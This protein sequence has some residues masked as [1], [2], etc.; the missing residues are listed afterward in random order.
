VAGGTVTSSGLTVGDGANA[1]SLTLSSSEAS[2]QTSDATVRS[3]SG[4]VLQNGAAAV[5]TSS[6]TVQTHGML[7]VRGGSFTVGIGPAA[8]Q[9]SIQVDPGGVLHLAGIFAGRV[10][11]PAAAS[12]VLTRAPTHAPTRAVSD[13]QDDSSDSATIDGDLIESA[14]GMI[15]LDLAGDS[16]TSGGPA[17]MVSGNADVEGEIMLNFIDGFAPTTGE[18]FDLLSSG[19]LTPGDLYSHIE[20][21]GLQPGWQYSLEQ[22][23]SDEVIESLNNAVAVPEPVGIALIAPALL[24]LLRRRGK[25]S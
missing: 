8:P 15:Q 17:L 5:A 6:L 22:Q 20:I 13:A 4:L 25:S 21:Q 12:N 9:G 19:T 24:L 10:N 23:N 14:G 16:V 2:L 11:M 7:D 1:S 18:T 3:G